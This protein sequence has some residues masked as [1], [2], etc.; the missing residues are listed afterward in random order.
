[1]SWRR[2]AGPPFRPSSTSPSR[3]SLLREAVRC[4]ARGCERERRRAQVATAWPGDTEGIR[5][6]GSPASGGVGAPLGFQQASSGGILLSI[7]GARAVDTTPSWPRSGIGL[8]SRQ[9][10][11]A[12]RPCGALMRPL[13][14]GDGRPPAVASQ[15]PSKHSSQQQRLACAIIPGGHRGRRLA[16]REGEGEA[17]IEQPSC[18]LACYP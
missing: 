17:I 10:A 5:S 9:H 18:L 3:R 15:S 8:G 2:L 1:M 6:T 4:G 7:A 16:G 13:R 11:C 14:R 12:W